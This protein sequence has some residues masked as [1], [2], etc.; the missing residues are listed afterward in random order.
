LLLS[1]VANPLGMSLERT[2]YAYDTPTVFGPIVRRDWAAAAIQNQ[3]LGGRSLR[4]LTTLEKRFERDERTIELIKPRDVWVELTTRS[5][6]GSTPPFAVRWG[7]QETLPAPAWLL[8]VPEWPHNSGTSTPATPVVRI[9][10]NPQR[11]AEPAGILVR[12]TDFEVEADSTGD[13]GGAGAR[14]IRLKTTAIVLESVRIEQHTVETGSPAGQ[15]VPPRDTRTCLVVRLSHDPA[16]PVWVRPCGLVPD[17]SEHRFYN[18]AGKYTA[19]FWTV[20]ADQARQF[21]THLEVIAID[22][23][24]KDCE[25]QR[26]MVELDGLR[27]PEPG[28]LPPLDVPAVAPRPPM[29]MPMPAFSLPSALPNQP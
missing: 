3:L 14:T 7:Y 27:T 22:D 23:F 10:W 20:N 28:S 6:A 24:K 1:L 9:W 8:T 17:G 2:L 15:P 29:P 25:R 5:E 13:A 19:L 4:V 26:C 18:S 16:Q 11:A 21:L 12:G